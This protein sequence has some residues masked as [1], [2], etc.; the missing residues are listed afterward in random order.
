MAVLAGGWT[1]LTDALLARL[2]A[3]RAVIVAPNG[4]FVRT[5]GAA[6]SQAERDLLSLPEPLKLDK[7][8]KALRP[9]ARAMEDGLVEAGLM[10]D[11]RTVMQL[12]LWQSSPYA[13]LLLFGAFK[14]DVGLARDKPVGFLTLLMILTLVLGVVRFGAVDR[15]TRA[16]QAAVMAARLRSD[17]LR[18]APTGPETGLAVALFGTT[19]LVGSGFAYLHQLRAPSGDSGSSGGDGGDGGGGG[20][21]CGGCGG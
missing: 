14:W 20:G 11:W 3:A 10:M 21:G 2:L 6:R 13:L 7:A 1:R 8:D 16:G 15:R 5:P 4:L 12:R 9:H 19:V 17:R 18:R